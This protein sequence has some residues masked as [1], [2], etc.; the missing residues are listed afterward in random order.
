MRIFASLLA[1]PF[2]ASFTQ[3]PSKC[4]TPP[5]SLAKIF[6]SQSPVRGAFILSAARHDD[7]TFLSMNVQNMPG[8]NSLNYESGHAACLGHLAQQFDVAVLQENFNNDVAMP[9]FTN[10]PF[11]SGGLLLNNTSGL[12]LFHRQTVTKDW[13]RVYS[14][15]AGWFPGE[16]LGDGDCWASKGFQMATLANGVT[17]VNTHMDAGSREVDS[18]VRAVQLQELGTALPTEGPLLL[19]GDFN[20]RYGTADDARLL[21]FL[22]RNRLTLHIRSDSE[23]GNDIIAAR[24]VDI[25]QVGLVPRAGLSDHDGLAI[26]FRPAIR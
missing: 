10:I 13:T 3:P 6:P 1:F 5:P 21:G 18:S 25:T 12:S 16:K 14:S 24:E 20:H 22:R 23:K 11:A 9:R 2:L 17:V 15:C 19:A 7:V 8:P 4:E 26:R